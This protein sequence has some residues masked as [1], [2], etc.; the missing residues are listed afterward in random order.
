MKNLCGRST[1]GL[2]AGLAMAGCAFGAQAAACY[3][4][5]Q[6]PNGATAT[7]SGKYKEEVEFELVAPFS[8]GGV[9]V[10]GAA[11]SAQTPQPNPTYALRI[12]GSFSNYAQYQ[13]ELVVSKISVLAPSYTVKGELLPT[14][15]DAAVAKAGTVNVPA[16]PMSVLL[17][18]RTVVELYDAEAPRNRLGRL[19]QGRVLAVL[20]SAPELG[21]A[22]GSKAA[23][24]KGPKVT[25]RIPTRDLG[26]R[27]LKT[28]EAVQ[29]MQKRA[30]DGQCA[31]PGPALPK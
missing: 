11:P 19:S 22:V 28:M 17:A 14:S 25:M 26:E 24:D 4:V 18:K 12:V 20:T 3:Q 29:Q 13:P 16:R 31:T 27:M 1:V 15:F 9:T 21:V 10:A 23:G 30:A 7:M 2:F 6:L 8:D 5:L